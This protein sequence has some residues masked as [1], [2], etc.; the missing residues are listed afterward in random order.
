MEPSQITLWTV[1][2]L[3][4][5]FTVSHYLKEKRKEKQPKELWVIEDSD[6]DFDFL[7]MFCHFDGTY[8]R[9]FKSA[10]GLLWRF[11]T[12]PPTVVLVDYYLE[13]KVKG[14]KVVLLCKLLDIDHKIMTGSDQSIEGLEENEIVR[15][16]TGREWCAKIQ[17]WFDTEIAQVAR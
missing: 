4:I 13:G 16:G 9:R 10:D 15:K 11:I 14:D 3:G 6:T 8:M 17:T 5:L 7:N 1:I 2:V 12:S